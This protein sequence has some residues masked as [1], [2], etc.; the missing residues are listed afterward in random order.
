M[1]IDEPLKMF[2]AYQNLSLDYIPKEGE[3]IYLRENSNCSTGGESINVTDQIP[4]KFKKI[5][6]KAAKVFKAKVC[7]VD[8]IINDLTKDNYAIIE[9]NDDP[10]YDINEWPYEGKEVKIGLEILKMLKLVK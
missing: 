6:E 9:I 10:G 7:G 8:I 1:K 5:A 3:R 2:L 4:S